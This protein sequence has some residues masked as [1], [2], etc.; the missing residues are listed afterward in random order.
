LENDPQEMRSV[1]DVPEYASTREELTR[2][3]HRLRTLYEAPPF[4]GSID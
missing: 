4:P 3:F 1:H 2:E